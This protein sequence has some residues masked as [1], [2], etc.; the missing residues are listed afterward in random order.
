MGKCAGM[1]DT[2]STSLYKH[3]YQFYFQ[4]RQRP[5]P[6]PAQYIELAQRTQL[7]GPFHFPSLLRT[8][9]RAQQLKKNFFFYLMGKQAKEVLVYQSGAV[10][11]ATE[12]L[13]IPEGEGEGSRRAGGRVGDW[14]GGEQRGL[15]GSSGGACRGFIFSWFLALELAFHPPT[16]THPP[17]P[18]S[19]G[20][21]GHLAPFCI[22]FLGAFNHSCCIYPQDMVSWCFGCLN[23]R[24]L[25]TSEAPRL[26]EVASILFHQSR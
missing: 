22:A 20:A 24:E 10:L 14:D 2:H 21:Q 1:R 11:T 16:P 5:S 25:Q 19:T 3:Q 8:L 26:H 23:S 6:L 18:G 9:L 17:S 15:W 12:D 13:A 4:P 7:H